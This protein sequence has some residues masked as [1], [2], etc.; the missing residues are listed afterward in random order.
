MD[1]ARRSAIESLI[2]EQDFSGQI[3][4]LSFCAPANA[5]TMHP[6]IVI[7]IRPAT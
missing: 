7:T 1:T 4:P 2:C 3:L 5:I 6:F